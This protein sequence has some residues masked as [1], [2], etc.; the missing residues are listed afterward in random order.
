MIN[1][2][3]SEI[4]AILKTESRTQQDLVRW[5]RNSYCLKHHARRCLILAIV[6][7]YK[8]IF[9]QTGLYTGAADLLILH[10][11]TSPMRVIFAEVKTEDPKSKQK[12][13][14]R[15][16]QA[17]IE[18]MAGDAEYYVVRTLDEFKAIFEK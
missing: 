18:Q 14:Q 3:N 9:I 15:E 10:R 1:S 6:N 13:A 12:P 4:K 5:Y 11:V 8:P 2:E 7:E 16:F 17:H